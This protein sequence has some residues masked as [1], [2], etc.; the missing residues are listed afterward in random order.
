MSDGA[1]GT[2]PSRS[3]PS[4]AA[5][6]NQNSLGAQKSVQKCV[7]SHQGTYRQVTVHLSAPTPQVVRMGDPAAAFHLARQYEAA[8]RISEAIKYYTQVG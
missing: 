7:D 3:K 5:V 4:Q 1:K 2:W 6:T 8:E